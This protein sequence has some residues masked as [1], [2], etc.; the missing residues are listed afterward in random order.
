M[1]K[2]KR[3]WIKTRLGNSDE[4]LEDAQKAF[5]IWK[6]WK[7]IRKSSRYLVCAIRL[8]DALLDGDI[9]QF[10][11]LM[12][13]YFPGYGMSL[14]LEQQ[15]PMQMTVPVAATNGNANNGHRRKSLPKAQIVIDANAYNEEEEDL[16]GFSNLEM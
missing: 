3:P 6:R 5:S 2:T 12:A 15:R 7:S 9:A 8:Y 14:G 13:R 4:I 16:F 1:P 11:K 10:H